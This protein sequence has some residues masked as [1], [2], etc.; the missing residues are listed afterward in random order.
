MYRT[1]L[2]FF[3]QTLFL[4][5]KFGENN[6]FGFARIDGFKQLLGEG[7]AGAGD[8]CGFRLSIYIELLVVAFVK[9][10]LVGAASLAMFHMDTVKSSAST[11][12]D[13]KPNDS[14]NPV[15]LRLQ[16]A[17]AAQELVY[18][19]DDVIDTHM[20]EK[21][22]ALWKLCCEETDKKLKRIG[23]VRIFLE[24]L[25][26][27]YMPVTTECF[28][29]LLCR[30]VSA[31]GQ[32]HTLSLADLSVSCSSGQHIA[33]RVVA[34]LVFF[35]YSFGF[36]IALLT[37]ERGQSIKFDAYARVA[38]I[39]VP[40]YNGW[41]SFLMWRRAF[42]VLCYT[43]SSSNGG[44]LYLPSQGAVDFR[45][46][47]F[48]M[49]A[50]YVAIQAHA[51]PYF[52]PSDNALEQVVLLV[53]ML[54]IFADMN[55]GQQVSLDY[56]N[57]QL[58]HPIIFVF[59]SAT[60][61]LVF[62]HKRLNANTAKLA[63]VG[64][65]VTKKV[66]IPDQ[67]VSFFQMVKQAVCCTGGDDSDDSEDKDDDNDGDKKLIDKASTETG[68]NPSLTSQYLA[69]FRLIDADA[70]G[71]V[72][73]KELATILRMCGE[74][75][76]D[77]SDVEVEKRMAEHDTD[78]NGLDFIEMMTLL[79][80]RQHE[81]EIRIEIMEGFLVLADRT[82]PQ[83]L[84]ITKE[85][86]RAHVTT[87]EADKIMAAMVGE[88]DGDEVDQEQFTTVLLQANPLGRVPAALRRAVQES[89]GAEESEDME[90]PLENPAAKGIVA[91]VAGF[92]GLD[93]S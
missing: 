34:G 58:K 64:L 14:K 73:L 26:F 32:E 21:T 4:L 80:S 28:M 20:D 76:E 79:V 17:R 60:V 63:K 41:M 42:L 29:L 46:L 23:K 84:A 40:E 30:S 25:M 6:M 59:A 81:K 71:F 83:Q 87:D 68:V 22:Q 37:A 93:D 31:T 12:D 75:D 35:A 33:A 67:Q 15:A 91:S 18:L 88:G 43:Y 86:L 74:S 8:Q 9:P 61:C 45:M 54:V 72:D 5:G 39:F 82:D 16:E 78:G 65:I 62:V 47:P 2:T 1:D 24:V 27:N 51:K 50:S 77:T 10:F 11:T 69:A 13:Y 3:V 44:L 55:L 7:N 36:P 57:I 89:G 90:N 38:G 49:L 56:Q 53:L 85:S 66:F 52:L 70:S 92:A 19:R 48:V